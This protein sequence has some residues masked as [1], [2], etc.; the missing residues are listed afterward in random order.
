M[1]QNN[2]STCGNGSIPALTGTLQTATITLQNNAGSRSGSNIDRAIASINA[3]LQQ[4][5]NPTLQ[6]IVAVKQNPGGV[7]K[8]NFLST[9]QSFSATVSALP[10]GAGL[11]AG[12]ASTQSSFP[13]GSTQLLKIDTQAG[14]DQAITALASAINRL[15]ATQAVVGKAEN[16]LSYA[17]NLA[18]SQVTNFSGAESLIRDSDFAAEA[19]NLS[20]AQVLQQSSIAVMAQANS[21]PQ[22]V[23]ALLRG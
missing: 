6:S 23:L 7:D 1:W 3:S 13:L 22:A 11:N 17:L 16:Q 18:Q 20:K 10:S 2:S 14:A 5:G 19:A 9:L 15:G 8:I 21:A 4:T 12:V